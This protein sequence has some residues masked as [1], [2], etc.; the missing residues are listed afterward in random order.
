MGVH[1]SPLDRLF[2]KENGGGAKGRKEGKSRRW[3]IH[4]EDVY[5][6]YC[7]YNTKMEGYTHC[8]YTR[9][10]RNLGGIINMDEWRSS[11]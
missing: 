3:E 4:S 10:R 6:Q 5:A 9:V 11:I 2:E 1:F 7:G 8:R